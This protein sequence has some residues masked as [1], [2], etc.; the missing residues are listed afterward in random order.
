MH[1]PTQPTTHLDL[2]GC[3]GL[4]ILSRLPIAINRYVRKVTR[5]CMCMDHRRIPIDVLH[6]RYNR[7]L[8][9]NLYYRISSTVRRSCGLLMFKFRTTYVYIYAYRS[10]KFRFFFLSFH[11]VGYTRSPGVTEITFVYTCS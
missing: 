9:D 10:G 2:T 11:S 7:N 6:F 4:R 5:L 1:I 3:N 8:R